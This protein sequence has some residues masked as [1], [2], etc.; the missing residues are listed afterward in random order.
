MIVKQWLIL[1]W[2]F[3]QTVLCKLCVINLCTAVR[4]GLLLKPTYVNSDA[5][6]IVNGRRMYDEGNCAVHTVGRRKAR[7]YKQIW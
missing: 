2:M 1:M 7:L 5:P 4:Q 3:F 6:G